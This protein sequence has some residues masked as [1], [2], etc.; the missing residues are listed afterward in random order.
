[1]HRLCIKE[2]STAARDTI[3]NHSHLMISFLQNTKP[4]LMKTKQKKLIYAYF[5]SS[6][7][8]NAC[9]YLNQNKIKI[10]QKQ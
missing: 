8:S 6:N 3:I 10:L 5:E 7:L 1:M 9:K 2:K 4:L